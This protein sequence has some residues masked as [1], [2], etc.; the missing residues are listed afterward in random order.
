[1]GC[2]VVKAGV[3][4]LVTDNIS[5]ESVGDGTAAQATDS[6]EKGINIRCFRFIKI[7]SVIESSIFED[8]FFNPVRYHGMQ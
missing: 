1:M 7:S 4:F 8:V 3:S 5:L 2:S 6:N